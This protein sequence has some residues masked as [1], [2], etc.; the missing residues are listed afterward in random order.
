MVI[1]ISALSGGGKTALARL[2]GARALHF[3]DIPGY[4]LPGGLSYCEWSESGAD[5][6]LW[7]LSVLLVHE[8]TVRPTC[9]F[10]LDGALPVDRLADF[11]IE[12]L[13]LGL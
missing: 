1:G 9:D 6:S 3:D 11:T 8:A 13:C 12:E 4:L 2:P 7:N 5:Y 10:V